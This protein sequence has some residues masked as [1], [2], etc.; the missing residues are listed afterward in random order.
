MVGEVGLFS[1]KGWGVLI[2]QP[3]SKKTLGIM[4]ILCSLGVQKAQ[5]SP[6]RAFWVRFELF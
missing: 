2:F 4:V 1:V 5:K 3:G 6:K